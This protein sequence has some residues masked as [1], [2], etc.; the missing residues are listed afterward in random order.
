MLQSF[1]EKDGAQFLNSLKRYVLSGTLVPSQRNGIVKIP[2]AVGTN[3]GVSI[4]TPLEGPQ[5]A[6]TELHS[7]T[8]AQGLSVI[9]LGTISS[10][11]AI[12]T[13]I[14]TSFLAQVFPGD[15][16][17]DT[18]GQSQTVLSVQSDTQFTT[19]VAFGVPLAGSVY[20][21]L[22]PIDAAA[23]ATISCMIQ[24]VSYQRFFMNAPVP[25]LHLF[26]DNQKPSMFSERILLQKNHVLR[27]QF[28]N[29][30]AAA[31]SVGFSMEGRKWQIEATEHYPE[32]ANLISSLIARQTMLSPY[33]LTLDVQPGTIKTTI[34]ANG[35]ASAT[36]TNTGSNFL[37][38]YFAYGNAVSSG[39]AG[40]TQ[41]MFSFEMIDGKTGQP[42]QRQPQTL[43]TGL[44]TAQNP[45][46][47]S[48][49][50]LIEPRNQ[51]LIKFKNLITDQPTDV[52]MTLGCTAL[53]G[54]NTAITDPN[55]LAEAQ[56]IY[57]ATQ[58]ELMEATATDI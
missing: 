10:A 40:D 52:F 33:W 51:V 14:G 28:F 44:G 18:T 38:A 1:I 6:H 25:V 30:A 47:F 48:T 5:D 24:D 54:P 22:T 39:V 41:E 15:T 7:L 31:A 20:S 42:L 21:I 55:L 26:G 27:Y 43:N 8:G 46:R 49:P 34:P 2:G 45:Y 19:A 50:L 16:I 11:A 35:S 57:A 3:L 58:P 53:L 17:K 29:P 37:F 23:Q 36:M 4:P 56:N 9:G 12:V 13:G 32:V